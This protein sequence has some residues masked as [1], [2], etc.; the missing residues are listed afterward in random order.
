[1]R[2]SAPWFINQVRQFASHT[3]GGWVF[4]NF[5]EKLSNASPL[6]ILGLFVDVGLIFYG[7]YLQRRSRRLKIAGIVLIVLGIINLIHELTQ[8]L[9]TQ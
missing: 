7:V 6:L 2:V 1:M 8:V 9:S 5:W 3:S 4:D